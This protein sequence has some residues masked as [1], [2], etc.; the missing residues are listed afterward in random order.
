MDSIEQ[1]LE[2]CGYS[3]ACKYCDNLKAQDS[4]IGL[5]ISIIMQRNSKDLTECSSTSNLMMKVT[6]VETLKTRVRGPL[7]HYAP[8]T[9]KM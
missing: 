6:N 3:Q 5:W 7:Q 1:K 4:V 2:K 8:E 9:F